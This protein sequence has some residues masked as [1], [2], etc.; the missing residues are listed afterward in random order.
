MLVY[1][2]VLVQWYLETPVQVVFHIII[3][4]D[5]SKQIIAPYLEI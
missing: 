4:S 5:P 3:Y 1:V 2:L